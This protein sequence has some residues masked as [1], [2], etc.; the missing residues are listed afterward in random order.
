MSEYNS[1]GSQ[2]ENTDN[3]FLN[4]TKYFPEPQHIPQHTAQHTKMFQY[5][6]QSY[7]FVTNIGKVNTVEDVKNID[8]SQE[9]TESQNYC[10]SCSV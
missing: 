4:N 10:E 6:G 7:D 1:L 5:P 9:Q 2:C 8:S 3:V